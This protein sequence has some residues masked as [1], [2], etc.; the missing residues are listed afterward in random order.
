MRRLGGFYV[1]SYENNLPELIIIGQDQNVR[2]TS[3]CEK[4]D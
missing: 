2:D 4:I 1:N 3:E